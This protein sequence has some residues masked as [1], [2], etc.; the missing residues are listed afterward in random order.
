MRVT[1]L[2]GLS[3]AVPS[4]IAAAVSPFAPLVSLLI[5]VLVPLYFVIVT[6]VSRRAPGTRSAAGTG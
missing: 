6:S 3:A 1:G 5:F 4:L 2:Q